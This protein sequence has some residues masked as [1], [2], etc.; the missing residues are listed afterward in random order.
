MKKQLVPILFVFFAHFLS[1]KPIQYQVEEVELDNRIVQFIRSFIEFE[2]G[3]EFYGKGYPI[4]NILSFSMSRS[5]KEYNDSIRMS[6]TIDFYPDPILNH[7]YD[8]ISY[9]SFVNIRDST[10]NVYLVMDKNIEY[11]LL[12]NMPSPLFKPTGKYTAVIK[13]ETLYEEYDPPFI[14]MWYITNEAGTKN[15]FIIEN[16]F[17]NY[18]W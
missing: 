6:L 2:N 3:C 7:V 18:C 13:T 16:G 15:K 4:N 10:Y 11:Q 5:S 1:A 12:E 17:S 9:V 14:R 8:N